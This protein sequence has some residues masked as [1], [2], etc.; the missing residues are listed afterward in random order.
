MV[1]CGDAG[2]AVPDRDHHPITLAEGPQGDL[3]RFRRALGNRLRGVDEQVQ[4]HLTEAALVA[5]DA[6]HVR[7]VVAHQPRPVA[8]LVPGHARARFQG[9]GH[10]HH[11]ALAV[12][13]A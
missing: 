4:H 11:A 9:V 7:P 2:A 6:R 8:D 10:V 12:I 5:E 13:G 1:L 3:V